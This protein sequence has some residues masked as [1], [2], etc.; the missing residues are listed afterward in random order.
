MRGSLVFGNRKN[1]YCYCVD[2][3]CYPGGIQRITIAKAN[4]LATIADNKVWIVVTDNKRHKP[5]LPISEKVSLVDLGI[6]YYADDWISKWHVLK[7]IF[8]KDLGIRRSFV[9]C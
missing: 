7:G 3:V 6:D 4:A 9:N 1:E 8:L 5:V 2:S